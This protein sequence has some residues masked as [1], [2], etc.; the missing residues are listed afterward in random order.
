MK[1]LLIPF[2]AFSGMLLPSIDIEGATITSNPSPAVSNKPLEITISGQD[3]G[4]E[5]YCYTW[6]AKIGVEKQPPYGWFDVNGKSECRMTRNGDGS[7]TFTVADIKS[8]YNLTDSELETLT[9]LGFIAKNTS[10]GQTGDLMVEVVQGRR[11]AYSG[12]EGTAANPF[13][14]KTTEDLMALASTPSDW[15][16]GTYFRMDSNIEVPELRSTIG[17][18]AT[19]FSASFDGNGHTIS[20][21]H[22]SIATF[23]TPAGLFGVIK[24]GEVKNL[25]VVASTVYGT[26]YIALLAGRL[27]SGLIQGCFTAGRVGGTSICVGGLAGE[28]ISG[29]ILDCYSG[30]MVENGNDYATGGLVGKNRGTIA[31][32]YAAGHVAG[33]DYTGGLVG[34]NYGTVKNS[35]ALNSMVASYND[36]S[37]RF[38]GNGNSQNI[39]SN[40]YSWEDIM[41]PD[42]YWGTHGHHAEMKKAETLRDFDLFKS[43]SGWDFDNV[44]EWR[45]D[46]N[47]EY[48]VL[49]GMLGQ[50]CQ[51]P[52]Y[53]FMGTTGVDGLMR[54]E[55][56]NVEIGPNPTQGVLRINASSPIA[57]YELHSLSGTQVMTG[58]TLS[59]EVVLDLGGL[60]EG[61]YILRTVTAEGSE[62]INKIIKK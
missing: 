2:L 59:G 23:G 61:L 7:Y 33:Y 50:Y 8:Y 42:N 39:T 49:K 12:G 41:A 35:F 31:N 22:L 48:P 4:Y 47:Q 6:C 54:E 11:D 16:A 10:G 46:G 40:N 13:I 1:K 37:A 56:V 19:P 24:G 21:L 57:R 38:G 34:A 30:A 36:F 58:S 9:S 52:E 20:D 27:E 29:T 28:N 55:A 45:K 62:Q 14:L 53:F 18:S 17:T 32:T 3:L 5:V 60:A 43:L 15:T 44:W 26:T 51:L 25:G